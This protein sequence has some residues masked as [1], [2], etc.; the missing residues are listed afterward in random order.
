M[1]ALL[2]G[3]VMAGFLLAGKL[4]PRIDGQPLFHRDLWLHLLNG[5][6]LF[7]VRVSL[8]A[9]IA[10]NSSHGWLSTYWLP[11]PWGTGR[12]SFP[13][14]FPMPLPKMFL[15]SRISTLEFA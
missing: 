7:I 10:A 14:P 3:T 15:E 8:I 6:A 2:Q 1:G 4:R 11:G 5:L 9:W 12:S 13:T